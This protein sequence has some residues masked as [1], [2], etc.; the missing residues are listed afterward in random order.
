MARNEPQPGQYHPVTACR[1]QGG[2]ILDE[3]GSNIRKATIV[4]IAASIPPKR[5]RSQCERIDYG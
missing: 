2:K 3:A 1:G 5:N 4:D